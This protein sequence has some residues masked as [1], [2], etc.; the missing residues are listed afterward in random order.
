MSKSYTQTLASFAAET[1]FKD[2]PQEVV[3]ASK[4]LIMD[5][6]G[7]TVGGSSTDLGR[8]SVALKRD[9]GGNPESTILVTGDKTSCTSAAYANAAMASAL[10]ADEHLFKIGH[11]GQCAI[12]PALA[13]AERVGASGK[14]LIAAAAIG[15]EIAG[16]VGDSCMLTARDQNGQLRKS[17]LG[18]Q[19]W[20]IFAAAAGASK[21]LGHDGTKMAH[22]LGIAGYSAP[23]PVGN[24]LHSPR[25]HTKSAFYALMAENGTAAALLADKGFTGDSNILDGEMGWWRLAGALDCNWD[26]LTR[27]LGGHWLVTEISFKPYPTCRYAQAPIDLLYQIMQEHHIKREEINGIDVEVVASA[28]AL[29]MDEAPVANEMDGELSIPYLMAMAASGM[30]P[31]PEWLA[32]HNYSD[33]RIVD[34]AREVK[35]R[36]N[37]SADQIVSE[38]TQRM[39]RARKAPAKVQVKARGKVFQ[40]QTDY[41]RGDPWTP[42]TS[43]SDEDLKEK[44]RA[45]SGRVLSAARI[46]KTLELLSKLE[47][48]DSLS[49]LVSCLKK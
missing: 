45:F 37:P 35:V 40:A 30:R 18:M 23:L 24:W 14:D 27:D 22:S 25:N 11:M 3:E 7:N 17:R 38:E 31:G 41:S 15:Y 10:C 28:L 4:R 39:G 6:V 1:G 8:I 16:R 44:F 36:P 46:E 2:L 34:L 9:L 32:P 33:P 49:P 19:N 29:H 48:Q 47:L 13:V 12:M 21:V 43:W 20:N 26:C 5:T 42:E